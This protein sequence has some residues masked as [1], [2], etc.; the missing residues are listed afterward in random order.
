VPNIAVNQTDQTDQTDQTNQVFQNHSKK[1]QKRVG[2]LATGNELTQGEILNT[3]SQIMARSL[4]DHGITLGEHLVV[5]DQE[6]NLIAAFNFLLSRHDAIIS[7]GGLGPTSDDLTREALAKLL[8]LDLI[9]NPPSYDRLIHRLAQSP[10]YQSVAQIPI[11]NRKQAYF[12]EGAEIFPNLNGTADAC[13][14]ILNH[15]KYIYLLPGPPLECLPI[16]EQYIIPELLSQNFG[17]TKR[18]H[19]WSLQD[20]SEAL[21]AELLEREL[22]EELTEFNLK[23]GYRAHKPNLDVKLLLNPGPATDKIIQKINTLLQAHLKK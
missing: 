4:L 13:R 19:R 20:V 17:S 16:F 11:S 6:D 21:I 3:N 10:R 14:V 12:P 22:A 15:Q 1:F 23:F 5:D 18:L 7:T 8:Q 2:F 9:F